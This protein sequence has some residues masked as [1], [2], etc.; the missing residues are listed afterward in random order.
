M[1]NELNIYILLA[2]FFSALGAK[3][4][5]GKNRNM[6]LWG[7]LG[8]LFPVSI[9]VLLCLSK[10]EA[11]REKVECPYCAELILEEAIVCKH[12]GREAYKKALP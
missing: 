5:N 8:F 10:K 12:C 9:V 1:F 11:Y 4:A 6:F 7:I 2:F 3:I